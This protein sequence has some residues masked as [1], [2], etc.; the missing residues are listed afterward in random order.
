MTKE[1]ETILT[2]DR[3]HYVCPEINL[4]DYGFQSGDRV[5]I[6]LVSSKKQRD[7]AE[8]KEARR[9]ELEAEKCEWELLENGEVIKTYPSHSSA[10]KAMY[11]KNKEADEDWLDLYYEIR[12]KEK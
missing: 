4:A 12:R 8:R 5:K 10:K 11:W 3:F 9:R 1:V 6:T 7:V 2:E